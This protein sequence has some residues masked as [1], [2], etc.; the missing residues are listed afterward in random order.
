MYSSFFFQW[1]RHWLNGDGSRM[2]PALYLL[3][4]LQNILPCGTCWR[5]FISS[6]RK[7]ISTLGCS[8][9]REYIRLSR[10]TRISSWEVLALSLVNGFG[11]HG[12]L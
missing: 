1:L 9:R 12:H 6:Q 4:Q 8:V 11:N 7:M 5:M 10:R 2:C 3:E